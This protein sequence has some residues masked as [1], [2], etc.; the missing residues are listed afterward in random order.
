MIFTGDWP[1]SAEAMAALDQAA[2]RA[3]R[4][5]S[6]FASCE[7]LL[8][9]LAEAQQTD[10][11]VALRSLGVA[12]SAIQA[13]TQRAVGSPGGQQS[14][15]VVAP[16]VVQANRPLRQ[17]VALATSGSGITTGGLLLG[18]IRADR[19]PLA[20]RL[21]RVGITESDVLTALSRCEAE[22]LG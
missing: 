21:L 12:R 16:E 20:R 7:D 18:L 5:A 14:G 3:S 9:A 15:A 19:S 11:V 8:D 13:P 6:T 4:R 1:V 17:A 2:V 22:R 10:A